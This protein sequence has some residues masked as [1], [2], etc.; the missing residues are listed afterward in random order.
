VLPAGIAALLLFGAVSPSQAQRPEYPLLLEAYGNYVIT[1]GD[2]KDL[3]KNG[4]SFGGTVGY[5]LS[6]AGR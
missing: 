2:F 1:T 4:V 3:A 5:A 6:F